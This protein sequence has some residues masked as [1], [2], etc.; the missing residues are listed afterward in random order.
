MNPVSLRFFLHPLVLLFLL[1]L[2]MSQEPRVTAVYKKTKF[3]STNLTLV[4]ETDD[5]NRDN[6]IIQGFIR[7]TAESGFG[8]QYNGKL[9]F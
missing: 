7:Y 5:D 8:F 2:T 3:S 6:K 4:R 9:M 1:R